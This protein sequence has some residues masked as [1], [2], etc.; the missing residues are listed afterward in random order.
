[1]QITRREFLKDMTFA[2]AVI[3]LPGWATNLDEAPPDTLLD[4]ATAHYPWQWTPAQDL[5]QGNPIITALN[6]IAFGPR[7]GDFERVQ[8]IGIDAYI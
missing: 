7:P 5:G 3:G 6:R 4:S 2:A 8:Q 1:M